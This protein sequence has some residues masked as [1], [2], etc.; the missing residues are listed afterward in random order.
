[1]HAF[2]G[3]TPVIEFY[4]YEPEKVLETTTETTTKVEADVQTDETALVED[5]IYIKNCFFN[6]SI[7]CTGISGGIVGY[8]DINSANTT[9]VLQG[10]NDTAAPV[11][12]IVFKKH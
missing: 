1:M 3:E 7:N 12:D 5:R 4:G 11:I 9:C 8:F 6:G 2:S 10:D